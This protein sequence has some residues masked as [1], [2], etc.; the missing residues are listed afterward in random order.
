MTRTSATSVDEPRVCGVP[1]GLPVI[2]RMAPCDGLLSR[3]GNVILPGTGLIIRRREWLG[4]SIALLFGICGNVVLSGLLIAPAMIPS[5]LTILAAIIA[6]LTWGAAQVLF[7]KQG[8]QIKRRTDLLNSLLE[9]ARGAIE[10]DDMTAAHKA[11]ESGGVLDDERVEL[12]VL[13]AA[14][15]QIEGN[16]QGVRQAWRRVLKLDHR[17]AYRTQAKEALGRE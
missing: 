17:G 3:L 15:R 8:T 7:W 11:L 13:W 14:L 10:R 4:M 5:W 16:E 1:S 9:D 12:H 2:S 6:L